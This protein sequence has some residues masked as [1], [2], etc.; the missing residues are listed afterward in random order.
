MTKRRRRDQFG[1]DIAQSTA[2][3]RTAETQDDEESDMRMDIVPIQEHPRTEDQL[4]LPSDPST[5]HVGSH[6]ETV[7]FAVPG[8]DASEMVVD[9][10][11]LPEHLAFDQRILEGFPL[12]SITE[13]RDNV[14][15]NILQEIAYQNN[16]EISVGDANGLIQSNKWLHD[17]LIPSREKGSFK[18]VRRLSEC[19]L[20]S[21]QSFVTCFSTQRPYNLDQVHLSP[22][23]TLRGQVLVGLS[24]GMSDML[25]M[26]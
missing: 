19:L 2:E 24:S 22:P 17:L 1:G 8:L 11:T 16:N 9:R 18:D 10:W 4:G 25:L 20:Y 23:W 7:G 13:L 6:A 14:L 21:E 3:W 5:S 26:P 15:P 12:S